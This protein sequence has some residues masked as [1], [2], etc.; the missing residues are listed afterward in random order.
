MADSQLMEAINGIKNSVSA[1]E[2]QLRTVPTKTDFNSII[3]EIRCVKENVIRNKDRIDTLYDLRKRDGEAIV[4]K[5]E[6]LVEGRM[7]SIKAVSRASLSTDNE[8]NYL[9]S[10]HSVRL[11]PVKDTSGLDAGVVRFLED[12]LQMPKE[13]IGGLVFEKVAKI[14]QEGP[15]SMGRF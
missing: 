9:R 13:V 12:C 10:R 4:K 7:S 15:R 14:S 5:V 1:M 11:W 2:Q 3:T 8:R 6:Q